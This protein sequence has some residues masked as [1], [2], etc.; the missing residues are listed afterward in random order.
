VHE[1]PRAAS[2]AR[3][4]L[5]RKDDG[6]SSARPTTTG[7]ATRRIAAM[8]PRS[9]LLILA[10]ALAAL[11]A[12]QS[13]SA[14]APTPRGAPKTAKFLATFKAEF[15]TTWDQPRKMTGGSACGGLNYEQGR[16][17]DSW[18]IKTRKPVKML[19]YKTGY[20][21]GLYHGTW[22]PMDEEDFT[23][24]AYGV[25]TRQGEIYWT[26]EPGSC[27]G[28]F[29][30]QPPDPDGDCGTRLPEYGMRFDGVRRI[31]PNFM[32]APHMRNEKTW[33]TDCTA[34]FANAL[35]TGD[36]PRVDR[37]LPVKA[38]FGKRKTV[39][40]TAGKSW[41]NAKDGT[42]NL[43]TTSSKMTWTLTLTRAK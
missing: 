38:L 20:G 21:A 12:A 32:N 35:G 16:G 14:I 31:H 43:F 1:A 40:V 36:W 8:L 17:T 25:H 23:F 10:T 42:T 30:R 29:Q 28:V 9:V 5:I 24:P 7:M 2:T 4:A 41:D 3:F 34:R 13:A 15:N 39:T 33:F 18:T 37:K 19:A 26:T 27:G 22:N 11:C 6:R